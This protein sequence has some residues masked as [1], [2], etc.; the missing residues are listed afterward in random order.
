MKQA[1][2][3]SRGVSNL[4]FCSRVCFFIIWLCIL[5]WWV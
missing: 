1:T 2:R 3:A 5:L 4:R